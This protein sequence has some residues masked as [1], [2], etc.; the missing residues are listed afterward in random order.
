MPESQG[1]IGRTLN[2]F[3]G[4]SDPNMMREQRINGEKLPDFS[5]VERYL[6]PAGGYLK[7]EE[8]GWF[9]VAFGLP[10]SVDDRPKPDAGPEVETASRVAP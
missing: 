3:L 7:A 5:L 6:G 9:T 4:P 10:R 2:E 8:D 1:L